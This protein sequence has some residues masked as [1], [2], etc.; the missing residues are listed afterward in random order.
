MI[1][2]GI[3]TNRVG[4]PI[5][6]GGVTDHSCCWPTSRT[7]AL[8]YDFILAKGRKL[9]FLEE[10]H[11]GLLELQRARSKLYRAGWKAS[12]TVARPADRSKAG[13][14]GGVLAVVSPPPP[15]GRWRTWAW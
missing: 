12:G 11:L 6:V 5:Q 7:T 14:M 2:M 4:H 15:S 9:N 1:T 3:D 10:H 8:A 13:A